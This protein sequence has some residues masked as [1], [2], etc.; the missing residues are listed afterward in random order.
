MDD[1][2]LM[3]CD[4]DQFRRTVTEMVRSLESSFAPKK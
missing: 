3:G 2:L 4:V 1:A